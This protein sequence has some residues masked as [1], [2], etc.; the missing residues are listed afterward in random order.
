MIAAEY[1]NHS[2]LDEFY[3]FI[4]RIPSDSPTLLIKTCCNF[5]TNFIRN[6]PNRHEDDGISFY[7]ISKWLIGLPIFASLAP[8]RDSE[9]DEVI[10]E[11]VIS[12]CDVYN[13]F[14]SF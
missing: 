10:F 11:D 7:S 4:L 1:Q 8:I 6:R 9:L 3:E 12:T 2:I 13:N 5:L 14:Y